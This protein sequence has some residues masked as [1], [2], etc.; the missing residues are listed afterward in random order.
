MKK[1]TLLVLFM[2]SAVIASA[3]PILTTTNPKDPTASCTAQLTSQ[4][5]FRALSTIISV[6]GACDDNAHVKLYELTPTGRKLVAEANKV[7]GVL[8]EFKNFNLGKNY[9]YECFSC[10]EGGKEEKPKEEKPVESNTSGSTS[11]SSSDSSSD[12]SNDAP[13]TSTNTTKNTTTNTT[14]VTA[15]GSVKCPISVFEGDLVRIQWVASDPDEEIG[16]QGNLTYEYKGPINETG[17]WQTKKGDAGI[18]IQQARVYD[19]ELYGETQ[20]CIEVI[21]KMYAPVL[22]V[23]LSVTVDEGEPVVLSPVCKDP[24]GGNITIEFSGWMNSSTRT[25]TFE[26]SGNYTVIVKCTDDDGEVDSATVKV[27]V[28]NKNRPPVI[29]WKVV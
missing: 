14:K 26:D 9:S 17:E 21:K 22:S 15:A 12:S 25:T 16:P 3:V 7:N 10:V 28:K 1:V 24:D 4:R 13:S 6:G 11:G 23:D 5:D 19:G 20:F 29:T 27:T 2:L 8:P 18:Y